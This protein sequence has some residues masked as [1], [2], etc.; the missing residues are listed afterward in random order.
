MFHGPKFKVE[1]ALLVIH[2]GS[3]SDRVAEYF[4]EPRKEGG[5]Y[6]RV[7]THLAWSREHEGFAQ[8]V[9]FNYEAYHVGGSRLNGEG[10]LNRKSIGIELA[11]PWDKK[12]G[13]DELEA[14]RETVT[15]ICN[16]LPSL[17]AVVRHS[18]INPRKKDPGPGFAWCCLDGLEL[19]IP[20][21]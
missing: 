3:I 6:C 20:F 18:D 21:R 7:S 10:G 4:Y 16:M 19:D 5:G 15:A 13:P 14:V 17:R 8:C 9:P 2:S 11:G 1:P 12:R